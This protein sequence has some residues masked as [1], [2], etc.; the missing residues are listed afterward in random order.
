MTEQD[1]L[2]LVAAVR[3]GDAKA[4]RALPEA[5][6]DPGAVDAD[7]GLPLLCTAVRAFADGAAEARTPRC[8][9]TPAVAA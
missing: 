2:R 5:G 7:T 8:A 9:G 1:D 4:V 3:A 6:A